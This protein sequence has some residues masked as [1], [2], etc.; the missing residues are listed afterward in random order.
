LFILALPH[1]SRK[2]RLRSLS[3]FC[4]REEFEA[5]RFAAHTAEAQEKRL[6]QHGS[7][8]FLL[9][10]DEALVVA[11]V[12]E[13]MCRRTTINRSAPSYDY[14]QVDKILSPE[15]GRL[16]ECGS[17]SELRQRDGYYARVISGQA[18]LT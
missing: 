3:F 15:E 5:R 17:P 13:L 9:V 18:K 12:H 16:T 4:T 11:S 6:A 10:R 8:L 1:L 2:L 14:C 7:E